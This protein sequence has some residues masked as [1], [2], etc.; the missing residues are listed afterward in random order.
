MRCRD[1][2]S[3][4]CPMRGDFG[5]DVSLFFDDADSPVLFGVP[6]CVGNTGIIILG[7]SLGAGRGDS[8]CGDLSSLTVLRGVWILSSVGLAQFVQMI[9]F[10]RNR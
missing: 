7:S 5:A 8:A 1:A 6:L 3:R 9:C 4:S 10:C 2:G